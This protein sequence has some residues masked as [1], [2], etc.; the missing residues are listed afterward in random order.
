M[1]QTRSSDVTYHYFFTSHHIQPHHFYYN[2][3]YFCNEVPYCKHMFDLVITAHGN[4]ALFVLLATLIDSPFSFSVSYINY[5]SEH[6]SFS[7][8]T[9][10][11]ARFSVRATSRANCAVNTLRLARY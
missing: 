11:S 3:S 2:K 7:F 9:C 1:N 8:V 6:I 5:M 10:A 4:P